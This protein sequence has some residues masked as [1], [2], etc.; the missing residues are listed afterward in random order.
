M[1]SLALAEMLMLDEDDGAVKSPGLN[2]MSVNEQMSAVLDKTENFVSFTTLWEEE[3]AEAL[4]WAKWANDHYGWLYVAWT[5]NAATLTPGISTDPA[6]LLRDSGF[7]HTAMI[8]AGATGT[9]GTTGTP[10]MTGVPY[11]MFIMGS[12][13]SVPWLRL[14]GT[15]TLAFKRQSGLPAT[16]S[17]EQTAAV[18]E[19]KQCNYVGNFATRNAAF[20][21]L[22][23]GCLSASDYRFIDPYINSIWLNNRLQ[24]SLMDG[25]TRSGRVP[26]NERGYTQ[27]RA[28]MMDPIKAA[29]NNAAI[30]AGIVLSEGQKSELFN[31]AGRDIS[32]EL[33]TQGY[34]I[35]ILDPGAAV[36]VK[37][38]SPVISLWYTY[39]GA[40]QK[41]D[42]ASTAVL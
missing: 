30:E 17:D 10:D 11:A 1:P 21:F 6:S 26:Y 29:L 25:L 14:N 3:T 19:D 39:G 41:I 37:R 28:W 9:A 23:P 36:R 40:V 15:I 42:V 24:V 35:Q 32:P 22:Y 12:V 4:A 34:Y 7:D 13:A 20:N 27:I 5:T 33:A 8:Y 2:A 38:E 18:L 16:V 31:E